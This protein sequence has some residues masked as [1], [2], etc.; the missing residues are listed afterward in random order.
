MRYNQIFLG[1]A[2][3]VALLSWSVTGALA[4][5]T[6]GG[7]QPQAS[8]DVIV[9]TGIRGALDEATRVKRSSNTIGEFI[10]ADDIGSLPALD[11]AEALQVVP[12]IQVNRENNDG[13]YRYGEISLR[14]LPGSFTNTTANGQS[15][16]A[17]SASVTPASGVGNPF[18]AF[19]SSIF[20]GVWV[21][22]SQRA[23]LIEGGIAGAVDKKLARAL[24]K[25]DGQYTVRL[26]AQYEDLPDEVVGN[27]FLA[28]TE[29]LIKNK[30]AVTF[31]LSHEEETFRR[32]G[33]N[34]TTYNPLTVQA[35]GRGGYYDPTG[36]T[37]STWK[38]ENGVPDTDTVL[39]PAGF[40]QYAEWREGSRTSFHG[41]VEYQSTPK[42]KLGADV[43]YTYRQLD[44]AANWMLMNTGSATNTTANITPTA[45]PFQITPAANG[46]PRWVVPGI[47][48]QDITYAQST[49][50]GKDK[51]GNT[52]EALGAFLNFE[53]DTSGW[54]FE[55]SLAY[56]EAEF[57]RGG[58]NLQAQLSSVD[59]SPITRTNGTSGQI[60]TGAG[61]IDNYVFT[62]NLDPVINP[63]GTDLDLVYP[64]TTA[65]TAN[66]VRATPS[67]PTTGFQ[68]FFSAGNEVFTD[69]RD[70]GVNL[71]V[72]RDL[73]LGLLKDVKFGGRYNHK[74]LSSYIF[75]HTIGG[76]DLSQLSNDLF[77][78]GPSPYFGGEAPGAYAGSEWEF[79]DHAATTALLFA[80][81]LNNPNNLRVSPNA[82]YIYRVDAKGTLARA[83]SEASTTSVTSAVYGLVNF[84]GDLLGFRVGGNAG[85]RYVKTELNGEGF[86]LVNGI[87]V[88][89]T[90]DSEYDNFL[91]A[92]N[93]SAELVEDVYLRLAYSEALTRPNPAGF[94]PS[95]S[96]T[97]SAPSGS[98]PFG[99]VTVNLPG[100]SVKPYT[101]VNYDAALEW[102]NR[103]GSL[104]SISYYKKDVSDFIS[105]R[106]VCP[107]DGAGLGF[108]T[109]T[110]VDNGAGS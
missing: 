18:G 104:F 10:S 23:D 95:T 64:S 33:I 93:F 107:T 54:L 55:G 76:L 101:S 85:G 20:D 103:K 75:E 92:V 71:D 82:G 105:T 35:N 21:N 6:A 14:G 81:G 78:P 62:L 34:F 45:V 31:K 67:T 8:D 2:S 61:D 4:Q 96:I 69:E 25:K 40:R 3:T 94:T 30:L 50:T 86:S 79:I 38:A 24:S 17:P 84:E 37:F 56:S 99:L 90:A 53:Y 19:S 100:T 98:N 41:G 109:L 22:K 57:F 47:N 89:A 51:N 91:P 5:Q 97:E 28:G 87:A 83:A 26:G 65:A 59:Q 72:T 110:A 80:N 13:A 73:G 58:G 48:Y 49:R 15:F 52:Q 16:A 108:G 9:V 7:T 36:K 29:H 11:L 42:L 1:A 68:T 88:P 63:V 46:T 74:E 102:Y 44:M 43:L 77:R 27:F 70:T 106:R 39:F 32:D 66:N 60:H 12:G